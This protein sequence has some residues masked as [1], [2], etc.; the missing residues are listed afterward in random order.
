M[1]AD[2][3]LLG[4]CFFPQPSLPSLFSGSLNL[5]EVRTKQQVNGDHEAEKAHCCGGRFGA[6]GAL[7]SL[8][9]PESEGSGEQRLERKG[10]GEVVLE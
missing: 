7:G 5:L 2:L 8:E 1:G 4:C 6:G 10:C 9:E 3:R